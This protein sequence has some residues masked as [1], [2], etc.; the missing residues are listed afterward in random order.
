[1]HSSELRRMFIEF[2]R[3]RG[4]TVVPSAPLVPEGDPT[5]LFTS[6]GMVQ[7]K[8]Y[9]SGSVP[10]PF[11]RA[12]S[13]QRCLRDE[14]RV[15]KT[16][17][18]NTFFEM[19][20]N[21][22]FGD[23]FK[24]EVIEWGWEF[25][26][27]VLGI[28]RDR[29]FI[30]VYEEDDE[31]FEIWSSEIGVEITR[32]AR[33]GKEDNFWGPAG[34]T[35]ACGPCSEIYIDLG[36]K[37]GCG[38]PTCHVGCECNRYSELWNLVFPQYDM[39][40][41]GN[42]NPLRNRGV[43]TGMGLERLAMVMQGVDTVFQTDLIM[44]VLSVAI[45][46][47]RIGYGQREVSDVSLRLVADHAR[48]LTFALAEG[49]L[50]SNE[51]RGYVLRRILRRAV[52][53]G[54]VLGRNEPFLFRLST[55]VVEN[56]K[57]AHPHLA[58]QRE[59]IALI[60]KHEEERFHETLDQGTEI[61]EQVMRQVRA[62]G[63]TRIPGVEAFRL[64]DTY[65][66]PLEL[67]QEMAAERGLGVDREGFA[68]ALKVQRERSRRV[69]ISETVGAAQPD[70]QAFAGLEATEF[71]GYELVEGTGRVL[72]AVPGD[73]SDAVR[74]VLDR[75][76]FYGE[77][78]GEVGDRGAICGPGFELRVENTTREGSI[79][80]H[81][82][83]LS[84]GSTDM[85]KPGVGVEARVDLD[86]RRA[87]ERNHTATH[88]LQA[89]LRQVL[90]THVHQEGS[91]VEPGRLRFDFTHFSAL[92]A[93]ERDRVESLVNERIRANT[94]VETS[95][96]ARD[97]AQERGALAFF[98]EKYG[99]E[100]RVVEVPGFSAELCGGTHVRST[101]EI[102]LFVITGEMG[103]AAGVRRI[104]ALTGEEAYRY[105]KRRHGLLQEISRALRGTEEE[106][107][108]RVEKLQQQVKELQKKI[109]RIGSGS[110]GDAVSDLL[111]Q[112]RDVDGLR[113]VW[114][115]VEAASADGLRAM[116][117]RV[118]RQLGS[119]VA[120][121]GAAIDNRAS[122][123][124]VVTDD[125]V[126][127]GRLKAGELVREVAKHAGGGGGGKPHLAEAGAKDVGRLKEALEAVPRIV[128][129]LAGKR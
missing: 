37:W 34:K 98:G 41:A 24:R 49:I 64:Y 66:F 121:L 6:A 87:T 62:S 13:V 47:T 96:I 92:T 82:A 84:A 127:L 95:L 103:V 16:P 114:G 20:G 81:E 72:S 106:A 76:P 112:A 31:S 46:E 38:K 23:Y 70:E 10:L 56:M 117:D 57:A 65:G 85:I 17:R 40:D 52:R 26:T 120:V 21:F 30:S 3:E 28:S 44:P 25:V 48:A 45:E 89:A 118:R 126:S 74:V 22:S 94:R 32:I 129:E 125:L 27:K 53:H 77:G 108:Q 102:G 83:R 35:G 124:A 75:T 71:V 101:G 91:L 113:V 8:P 29:L 104:E 14:D 36:E 99:D 7:F 51:G 80:V 4:H 116:G 110:A 42:L 61:L 68:G 100:V 58:P 88:L 67:T 123:L 128:R 5:L 9:Y 79:I 60:I 73:A 63:N 11:T 119:G 107:P 69:S 122:F 39:D 93:E 90:G 97:K 55:V 2:F 111:K 86:L 1:M 12:V 18:H 54:K 78:G 43:D 105:W 109:E 59:R 50:P 19:L 15:G 33:L 115:L